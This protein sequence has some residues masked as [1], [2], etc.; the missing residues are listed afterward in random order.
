[1]TDCTCETIVTWVDGIPGDRASINATCPEHGEK[2][3]TGLDRIC[4]ICGRVPVSS[5]NPET[6]FCRICWATGAS[7]ER[8]LDADGR[9]TLTR[10]RALP[11]VDHANVW[12]TGGGCMVLAVTLVD[13][14]LITASYPDDAGIPPAEG[15]WG[16]ILS[17]TEEAWSE[18]DE[19]KL[20]F[21]DLCSP[22]DEGLCAFV[23]VQGLL[24]APDA[25]LRADAARDRYVARE[26]VYVDGYAGARLRVGSRVK[27]IYS[28]IGEEPVGTLRAI[29]GRS[30]RVDWPNRLGKIATTSVP[31]ASLMLVEEES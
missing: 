8:D 29:E 13:D 17:E 25:A 5:K 3:P 31:A 7:E 16:V 2:D 14:R 15:P 23:A 12:Q 22:G 28:P 27:H 24:A 11:G 30:V 6:D 26:Q 18:W 10:L 1:M 21:P 19:T 9:G 20:S 4:A